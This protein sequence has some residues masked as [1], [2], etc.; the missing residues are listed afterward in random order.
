VSV[1]LNRRVSFLLFM[2]FGIGLQA[3]PVLS[4]VLKWYET[5]FHEVSHA[6]AAVLTGGV[7]DGL[8]LRMDGS[9]QVMIGGGVAWLSS[10]AGYAGATAC[11]CA[12]YAMSSAVS[13]KTA[14]R[15]AIAF[16]IGCALVILC[17]VHLLDI[18][19]LAIIAMI[20]ASMLLLAHPR[21]ARLAR[22]GLRMIGAYVAGVA[23]VTPTYILSAGGRHNDAS[24]LR[25]ML[26]LPEMFWV[27]A[28]LLFGAVCIVLTWRLEGIADRRASALA[29]ARPVL[30]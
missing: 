30:R 2:L 16:V 4:S 15:F 10:F 29:T 22:P 11:G 12:V 6:L 23:M 27:G 21:M 14:R 8:V 19:T 18:V 28:W 25:G 3:V 7:A 17:W 20:A 9:G 24:A 1:T 26:L 13:D 5:F